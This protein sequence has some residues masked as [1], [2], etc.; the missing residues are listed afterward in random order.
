MSEPG[1][2]G[3]E[4][5]GWVASLQNTNDNRGLGTMT[6]FQAWCL[7]L[8]LISRMCT[9][10][11]GGKSCLERRKQRL[12]KTSVFLAVEAKNFDF[13]EAK[14]NTVVTRDWDREREEGWRGIVPTSWEEGR[15]SNAL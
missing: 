11:V 4:P 12:R 6:M 2:R 3:G 8:C 1:Q 7:A 14:N 9:S 10:S 15:T 13:K 5:Q